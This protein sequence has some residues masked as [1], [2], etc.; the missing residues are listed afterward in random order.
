MKALNEH[1]LQEC[2]LAL[3]SL[4]S[5]TVPLPNLVSSSVPRRKIIWYLRFFTTMFGLSDC[6]TET[7]GTAGLMNEKLLQKGNFCPL[8]FMDDPSRVIFWIQS[9]FDTNN[10]GMIQICQFREILGFLG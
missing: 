2:N 5:G 3:F 1:H 8:Q 6:R 9:R 4:T 10:K 7:V